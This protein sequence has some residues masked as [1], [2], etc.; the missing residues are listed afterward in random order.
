MKSSFGKDIQYKKDKTRKSGYNVDSDDWVWNS[1]TLIVS[2]SYKL[3][4]IEIRIS[5]NTM[6][7]RLEAMVGADGIVGL[8]FLKKFDIVIL[9]YKNDKIYL[10]VH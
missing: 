2:N 3:R 4:N 6:S 10:K 1:D 9:D 8:P 7:D 5:K